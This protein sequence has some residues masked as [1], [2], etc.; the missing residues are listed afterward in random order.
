MKNFDSNKW[1]VSTGALALLAWQVLLPETHMGI[2]A[3]S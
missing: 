2:T 1:L 3:E